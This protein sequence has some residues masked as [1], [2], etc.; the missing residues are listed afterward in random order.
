[1]A[2]APKLTAEDFAR[3]LQ[4]AE[5]G[6]EDAQ[7]AVGGA[8]LNGNGVKRDLLLGERWLLEAARQSHAHAQCDLGAMYADGGV[9]KQSYPDA[10]KWLRKAADQGDVLAMAGLGSVYG[11]GF[12]DKSAGF[13]LRV[14]SPMP[15]STGLK[16]TSGSASPYEA[17]MRR[18][19]GICRCSSA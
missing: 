18:P 15:L 6:D 2:R 7:Y 19:R 9:L 4:E 5:A 13:F 14:S 8:Y 16:R 17:V 12:R 3:L 10:L 11:R 1:M